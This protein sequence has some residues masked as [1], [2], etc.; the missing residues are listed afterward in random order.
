MNAKRISTLGL[1][2]LFIALA[3][4]TSSATDGP[5]VDS[6]D[7]LFTPDEFT[8]G[9]F[10]DVLVSTG[11]VTL[12]DTANTGIYLSPVIDAPLFYNAVVP[13]WLSTVPESA[14]MTISLRTGTDNGQ[15]DEWFQIVQND[16]WMVLESDEI[17]GQMIIVPAVDETHQKIQFSVSFSRY[18]RD[19]AP[20]L[21]ELRL[22]FIDSSKGPT[23]EELLARQQELEQLQ[24]FTVDGSY[25]K[26]FVISRDTWCTDPRCDYTEGLEYRPVTHLI[27]H[28]TVSGNSST[29]WAAVVRAIW[30]FHHT[31][32][33]P[34]SCW[35]DVGYNYLVDMNGLLYEGHL[36]GDDVVGIH[37]AAANAGSMAL[38]FIGTFTAPDY[39][40]L[41]GIPPPQAMKD[42]AAELFAWKA[43]KN[44]ID[45]Y[46]SSELPDADWMLPHLMGHR[47]VYGTTECPGDQAYAILPWLRDQVNQ[48]INTGTPTIYV[49]ELSN[50]FTKSPTNYWYVPPD[51]CGYD[52]HAFYTWS[53]DSAGSSTNWGK[54]RPNIPA[55]GHYEIEVFAPYCTT[56]R[57]E[58]DGATYKIT[59]SQGTATVVVSHEQ[60]V[61]SWMS[62][63][64]FHL[65]AGQGGSI[66]LTDLTAT[67]SGLGVWFDAI[68]LR[69][70]SALPMPTVTND[71]P[72]ATVWVEQRNISFD[73]SITTASSV[74]TTRL[75]IAT[76]DGFGNLILS[77]D[78]A[79]ARTTYEHTFGQDYPRLYW[80]IILST[81]AGNKAISDSTF[82][83]I[84]TE[85]PSSALNIIAKME[86]GQ[87]ALGWQGSDTAS[88][89]ATYNIDY[90]EQGQD[91]LRLLSNTKATST[92]FSQDPA[93]YYEYRSQAIDNLGHIELDHNSPDVSTGDAVEVKRVIMFPL[94]L[95]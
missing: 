91:W 80:R 8:D 42:S 73:W 3:W 65:E 48:R 32:G 78:F 87:Y 95:P 54:W 49:D 40:N 53:V 7:L 33:C 36:G 20:V 71:Q 68:R 60:N 43:D 12:L 15:W 47:D 23:A 24:P 56:G 31:R 29:N 83:G 66:Y 61:G 4:S 11:G 88:G 9:T 18:A 59:H 50:E 10:Q 64:I 75:E 44:G 14:S 37:A 58:T 77:K 82:F 26:P 93:K 45:V 25:P 94:I 62:L 34:D 13:Q 6:G 30:S 2:L 27:V 92:L 89:V 22:T 17:V 41:P 72:L 16:D 52:G 57:A 1:V 86:D 76:D 90:R 46:G 70:S 38:S 55:D 69:P 51:S 5:M 81:S 85:P 63:G 19:L 39:P 35:G 21:H 74:S 84:D 79:G 28:H 67:D